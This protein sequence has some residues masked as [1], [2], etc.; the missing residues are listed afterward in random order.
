MTVD[1]FMEKNHIA[2]FVKGDPK[3]NRFQITKT[4][5]PLESDILFEQ[6]ILY[7]TAKNLWQYLKAQTLLPRNWRYGNTRCVLC[8]CEDKKVFYA[9]FYNSEQDFE[10]DY[11]FAKRLDKE[12]KEI[13]RKE[14]PYVP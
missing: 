13:I 4:T 11:C 8:R 7:N 12:L 2:L 6:L 10:E 5:L 3:K 9:L 14:N 1:E